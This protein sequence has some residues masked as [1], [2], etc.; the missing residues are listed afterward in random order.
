MRI[1]SLA[2]EQIMQK[3]FSK[4][5][6][7]SFKGRITR[8]QYWLYT[9][10]ASIL[11]LI[12]SSLDILFGTYGEGIIRNILSVIMIWPGLAVLVKRVHDR[13]RSGWTLLYY[14]VP[15]IILVSIPAIY[16]L[17]DKRIDPVVAGL[18]LLLFIFILLIMLID[19]GFSRGTKGGNK[20]GPDPLAVIPPSSTAPAPVN[21]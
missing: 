15:E 10:F 8:K 16:V 21:G 19:L 5:F 17:F 4:Q 14:F 9:G 20:Y 12:A 18:C 1:F 3:F 6:F 7:F 11:S 2:Q 13:A